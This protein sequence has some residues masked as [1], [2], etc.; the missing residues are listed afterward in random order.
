MSK[1]KLPNNDELKRLYIDNQLSTVDIGKMYNVAHKNVSLALH[2]AGI[3]TRK[4][5]RGPAHPSW[6]G[7][8]IYNGEY[9]VVWC[10]EHPRAS[11]KGYMKEHILVAEKKIGRHLI[12]GEVVHH[13]NFNKTD[14]R[15]ENLYVFSTPNEHNHYH[16]QIKKKTRVP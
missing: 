6:K 10:P 5:F 2:K 13:I 16:E 4:E 8:R 12:P 9:F 11:K 14:N 15:P 3:E 7:G 1:R